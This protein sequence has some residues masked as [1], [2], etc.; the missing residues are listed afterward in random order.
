LFLFR[1]WILRTVKKGG[2]SGGNPPGFLLDDFAC[3]KSWTNR[4]NLDLH[5]VA[6][7]GLWNED[8]ETLDPS[9]SVTARASLLDVKLVFF[10]FLNWLIEGTFKAHAF[11]LVHF[12]QLVLRE[13]T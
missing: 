7:L 10:A 4:V 11:H 8:Y 12:V 2:K 6:R 1:K 5:M 13:K 9:Y 3:G